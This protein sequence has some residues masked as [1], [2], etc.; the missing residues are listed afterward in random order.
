MDR[1]QRKN[2]NKRLM[3]VTSCY[4]SMLAAVHTGKLAVVVV[5]VVVVAVA[6]VLELHR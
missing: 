4:R 6:V 2:N 5:F 3:D 1:R